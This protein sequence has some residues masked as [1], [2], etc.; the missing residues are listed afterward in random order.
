MQAKDGKKVKVQFIGRLDDGRVF[1][2]TTA[3]HPLEFTLGQTNLIAGFVEA[4][5][6]MEA[7]ERKSVEVPA[8]NAFGEYDPGKLMSFKRTQFAKREPVKA[9]M[10]V[11]LEDVNGQK[12]TARVDSFSE[13]SVTLDLNHP[14]AGKALKFDIELQEVE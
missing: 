1:S 8:G 9:G 3:D 13:E 11:P 10:E 14:L 12:F 6:G 7:G 2:Q 4:I 5:R